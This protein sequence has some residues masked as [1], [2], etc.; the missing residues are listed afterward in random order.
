M[1]QLK[2]W[3]RSAFETSL[4]ELGGLKALADLCIWLPSVEDI[5]GLFPTLIDSV[6]THRLQGSEKAPIFGRSDSI[7]VIG[8]GGCGVDE[9]PG[10][11]ELVSLETLWCNRS[12]LEWLPDLS[13]ALFTGSSAIWY[14][15]SKGIVIEIF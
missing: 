4:T 12:E 7:E 2:L 5:R 1:N 14:S 10:V 15:I 8:F 6:A 9:I 13:L 11:R 3:N